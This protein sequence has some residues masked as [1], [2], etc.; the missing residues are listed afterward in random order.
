MP[1]A[2]GC[3]EGPV[4][5]TARSGSRGRAAGCLRAPAN[6]RAQW[7]CGRPPR[8]LPPAVTR[9]MTCQPEP[10]YARSESR[11]CPPPAWELDLRP[12]TGAVTPLPAHRHDDSEPKAHPGPP[13]RASLIAQWG[14]VRATACMPAGVTLTVLC[15]PL[16]AKVQGTARRITRA[17]C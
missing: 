10:T 15:C 6:R 1:L 16:E 8:A 2:S 11:V 7:H 4:P 13:R 14:R 3:G 9:T 17:Q 5:W 12:Q